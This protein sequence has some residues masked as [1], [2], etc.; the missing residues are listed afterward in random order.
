MI[1]CTTVITTTT[2]ITPSRFSLIHS[3]TSFFF[4]L[5]LNF[6]SYSL[7]LNLSSSYNDHLLNTI[8]YNAPPSYTPSVAGLTTTSTPS[9]SS[10]SSPLTTTT[11]NGLLLSTTSTTQPTISSN[12]TQNYTLRNLEPYTEYLVTLRVFNPAGDGPTATLA[13]ST[14]EG[15]MCGL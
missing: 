5:L 4:L 12:H 8:P 13:A 14:D 7:S 6:F 15:G 2:T 9:T 11:P 1:T 3:L 10:L